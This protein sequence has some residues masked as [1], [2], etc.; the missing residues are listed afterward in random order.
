MTRKTSWC[1][2]LLWRLVIY[3]KGNRRADN[4]RICAQ[5]WL[6]TVGYPDD[7]AE[8]DE[9]LVTET[10]EYV[11]Y[12]RSRYCAD[13]FI[14]EQDSRESW[15]DQEAGGVRLH[16]QQLR[17]PRGREAQIGRCTSAERMRC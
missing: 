17:Q 2:H 4:T 15:R 9:K 13:S 11:I 16:H 14:C 5:E 8:I 3:L 7:C 10:S 6:K 12:F 1:V